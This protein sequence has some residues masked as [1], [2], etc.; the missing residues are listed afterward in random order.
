MSTPPACAAASAPAPTPPASRSPVFELI[1]GITGH[2][3]QDLGPEMFL[4]NDLGIDSIKMVELAQGLLSQLPAGRREALGAGAAADQLKHLLQL[5]TVGDIVDWFEPGAARA[6]GT[7]NRRPPSPCCRCCRPSTP[8]WSGIGRSRPAAWRRGCACEGRSTWTWR[9]VVGMGCWHATRPCVGRFAIP[10]GATCFADYR[11]EAAAQVAAPELVLTDLAAF[12]AEQ[13][14]ALVAAEV[15]R[16]AS[17][18]PGR[19]RSRCCTASSSAPG[20]RTARG[21]LHQPPPHLRRH[22]QP[23]G[24]A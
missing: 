6:A 23:A 5:Q 24:D 2:R 4:E 11:Y 18:T 10:A 7:S 3:P 21:L 8:S 1:A 17:T 13:Q 15:E 14:D 20:C 22:E 9:G 12:D 19:S 16:C